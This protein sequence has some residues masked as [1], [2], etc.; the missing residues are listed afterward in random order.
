MKLDGLPVTNATT[1]LVLRVSAND[2]EGGDQKVPSECAVARCCRR[3]LHAKEVRVHLGRVYL[4][5]D[6][7]GWLRYN[8]SPDLRLEIIVFD[9]KGEFTPGKYT[10]KPVPP[11]QSNGR[12]HSPSPSPRKRKKG[13]NPRKPPT[14]VRNVR[15]GRR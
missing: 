4:R 5:L 7:T 10:L 12:A 13:T 14:V 1:P 8:T 6:D 3:T 15:S 11:S 9:R 2:I